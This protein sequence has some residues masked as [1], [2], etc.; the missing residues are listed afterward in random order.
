MTRRSKDEKKCQTE[1]FY[2]YYVPE[3][4]DIQNSNVSAVHT[5]IISENLKQTKSKTVEIGKQKCKKLNPELLRITL[6]V[7][8]KTKRTIFG[9]LNYTKAQQTKQALRTQKPAAQILK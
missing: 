7:G 8:R 2:F 4:D 6:P 3:R 9:R 5:T 1:E